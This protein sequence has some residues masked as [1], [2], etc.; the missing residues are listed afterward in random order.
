VAQSSGARIT[1][2]GELLDSNPDGLWVTVCCARCGERLGPQWVIAKADAKAEVLFSF[3][4]GPYRE[5]L[6]L[7]EGSQRRTQA[8]VYLADK[9]DGSPHGL[10]YRRRCGCGSNDKRYAGNLRGHKV[11]P[12]TDPPTV[13]F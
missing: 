12:R 10:Y 1:T 4:R 2:L 6:R 9:N 5:P 13:W 3:R 8:G 7:P 11:D